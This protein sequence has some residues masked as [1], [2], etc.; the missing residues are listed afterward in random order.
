M[1]LGTDTLY[2][3]FVK[4]DNVV[5]SI[6]LAEIVSV[7]NMTAE[8]PTEQPHHPKS[9]LLSKS[10]ASM[11]SKSSLGEL[12]THQFDRTLRIDTNPSGFNSGAARPRT[13]QLARAHRLA[14]QGALTTCRPTRTGNSTGCC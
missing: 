9:L 14:V 1:V 4:N 3:S 11:L 8:P 12:L 13:Q 6:P 2:F 5:D 10:S 7:K